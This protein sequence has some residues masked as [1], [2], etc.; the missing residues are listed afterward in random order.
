MR[1]LIKK[2]RQLLKDKRFR[3]IWYRGVSSTAAVVV[4]ITT[5]ALVLPAITMESEASCGIPAHQHSTDCYEEQLI[6]DLEESDDHHHTDDC[7]TVTKELTCTTPEHQ[8]DESCFDENGN[9]T[10]SQAEHTHDS[11]CY[12]EHRELTCGLE[13][14]EGHHHDSSCYKQV[15]TCGLEAHIHSVECYKEDSKAVTASTS[16]QA[17]DDFD[18]AVAATA[19]STSVPADVYDFENASNGSNS[20]AAGTTSKMTTDDAD[21]TDAFGATNT[22]NAFD[23]NSSTAELS[24]AAATTG[25]LPEPVEQEDLS[26]GYVPTLDPV[27]MDQVLDK[28]TGFYYYHAEE[29]EEL[30]ASSTEITS[31]KKVDDNTELAPTDLVKAYF[32]YTIPAGTLNETNQVARYRLPSNL[33]LTDDQIIAINQQENG[34]AASY[35]DYDTLQIL[36]TDNYHKYLGAEAKV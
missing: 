12:E 3:K 31:W 8:H 14:S 28:H 21:Q 34:I 27:N 6:C 19:A 5:Y 33:H 18:G 25:V 7:Y 22:S 23:E 15:L 10:C 9:L 26:E 13:E 2:I 36:D 11:T 30:P 17:S 32:A 24:S 4:F 35:I 16:I 29:G 20:S 1:A